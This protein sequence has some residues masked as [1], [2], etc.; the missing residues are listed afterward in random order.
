MARISPVTGPALPGTTYRISKG[1]YAVV[2]H[3]L[4]RRG[5]DVQDPRLAASAVIY[6]ADGWYSIAI[7]PRDR[8]RIELCRGSA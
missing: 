3:L 6:T 8:K 1:V 5:C 4:D 7:R 2:T